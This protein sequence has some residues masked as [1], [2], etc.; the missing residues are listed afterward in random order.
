[1]SLRPLRTQAVRN[2]KNLGHA[3]S[4]EIKNRPIGLNA[5]LA[6]GLVATPQHQQHK[7]DTT[8]RPLVS[9]TDMPLHSIK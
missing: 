6:Q 2:A 3:D 5:G 8:S 1:M 7:R 9:V 4:P